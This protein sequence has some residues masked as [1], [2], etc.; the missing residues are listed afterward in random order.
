MKRTITVVITIVTLLGLASVGFAQDKTEPKTP[1]ANMTVE[2]VKQLQ[3]GAEILGKAFGI[4]PSNAK[5]NATG[6]DASTQADQQQQ[7][8]AGQ[9]KTLAD[10]A[11]KGLD[12]V[13]KLVVNLSET[14]EKVAPQIWRVM[15]KQQYV[16]AVADLVVPWGLVIFTL[17][18]MKVTAGWRR[19]AEAALKDIAEHDKDKVDRDNATFDLSLRQW[20]SLFAPAIL[21]SFFVIWGLNRLSGSISYLVN[22]EF[23]AIRDLLQMIINPSVGL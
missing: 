18:W 15:V 16:K 7:S 8:A 3:Q 23:Y 1:P 19:K 4:Q 22:P 2:E 10:V 14:L 5:Q 9:P 13:Q 17:I 12:M 21:G 6:S 20:V 11:D